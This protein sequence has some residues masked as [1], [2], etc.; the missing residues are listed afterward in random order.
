MKSRSF[1]IIAPLDHQ[2]LLGGCLNFEMTDR[3][4]SVKRLGVHLERQQSVMLYEEVPLLEALERAEI[5][6]LVGFFEY[7]TSHPEERTPYH[8]FPEKFTWEGKK[9]RIRK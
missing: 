7:N 1:K 5:S 8:K 6:E 9:W 3:Y 4:P 2:K